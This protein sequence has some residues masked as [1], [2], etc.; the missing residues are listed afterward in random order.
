VYIADSGL[1]CHLLGIETEE[2]LK[3][4]PFRGA[5]FEGFI[6]SEIVK[7]QVHAGRR[8]ELYYFRDQQGLGSISWFL[9]QAAACGWWRPQPRER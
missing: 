2:E 6:A 4:S 3:K 9:A 1:A 7:A 5:I 8:R